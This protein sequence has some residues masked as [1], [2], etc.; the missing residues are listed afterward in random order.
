[1]GHVALLED[2]LGTLEVMTETV[3]G[4]GAARINVLGLLIEKGPLQMSADSLTLFL[5]FSDNQFVLF[6]PGLVQLGLDL[7]KSIIDHLQPFQIDCRVLCSARHVSA[8][9]RV[10]VVTV[11]TRI[12]PP[13]ARF[14]LLVRDVTALDQERI[15]AETLIAFVRDLALLSLA[16]RRQKVDG[17]NP[18]LVITAKPQF[19]GAIQAR[20]GVTLRD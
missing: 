17:E 10:L 3:V 2:F 14:E 5:E 13:P 20:I 11:V 19:R 16:S 6:L 15:I 7:C 9:R 18:F 1:L 4:E 8:F 12:A